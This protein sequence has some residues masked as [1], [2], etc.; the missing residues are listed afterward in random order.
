M[1]KGRCCVCADSCRCRLPSAN[2]PCEILAKP[3]ETK[4][5][6]K[7]ANLAN[8]SLDAKHKNVN[9]SS[10]RFGCVTNLLL[11]MS[12]KIQKHAIK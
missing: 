3:V 2:C 5:L 7:I 10:G 4:K 8:S 9:S 6:S 12:Y 1:N 11:N